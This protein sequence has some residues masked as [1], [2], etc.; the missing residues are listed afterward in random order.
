MGAHD[1]ARPPP[2]KKTERAGYSWRPPANKHFQHA[3]AFHQGGP[4]VSG[5]F[6]FIEVCRG[7]KPLYR[8][9]LTFK[10]ADMGILPIRA[11]WSWGPCVDGGLP[12]MDPPVVGRPPLR[13]L[14][15][16]GS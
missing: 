14:I 13:P 6:G 3:G 16:G 12:C 8:R 5:G 9:G 11:V 10:L 15:H 1:G 2:K 4:S 7:G